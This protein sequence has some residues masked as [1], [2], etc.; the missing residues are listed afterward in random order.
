MVMKELEENIFFK[1]INIKKTSHEKDGYC[2][3]DNKIIH[4]LDRNMD[5][6]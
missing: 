6:V 4:K 2:Y 5:V 3:Y 1:D